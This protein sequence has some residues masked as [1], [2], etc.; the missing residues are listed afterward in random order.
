MGTITNEK[1]YM[2]IGNGDIAGAITD[3]EDV[4]FFASGVSDSRCSDGNKFRREKNLLI[5]M[6]RHTHL[7]YFSTLS[8]YYHHSPYI[9]HK[10]NMEE[11]VKMLFNSWTIIRIGNIDWG[12]NPNTL[13]NYLRANPSAPIQQ[14]WRHIISKEEFQYWLAMIPVKQRNEMNIPGKMVWVPALA[15]ALQQDTSV[16]G[17]NGLINLL[18]P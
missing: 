12:K 17:L 2:I 1:A 11:M 18:T 15:V 7:V 6:P 13:I 14:V 9:V 4:T 3:R 16:L 8:I 5:T 10:K